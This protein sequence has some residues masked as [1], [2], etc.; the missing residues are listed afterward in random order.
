MLIVY[1]DFLH[2]K[3]DVTG[4]NVESGFMADIIIF[5]LHRV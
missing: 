3:H 1:Y 5:C 2:Q 4:N